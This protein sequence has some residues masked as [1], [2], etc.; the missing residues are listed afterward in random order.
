MTP[1]EKSLILINHI[2]DYI[3]RELV[4]ISTSK[5][6]GFES[7]NGFLKHL[8]DRGIIYDFCV[9]PLDTNTRSL[10]MTVKTRLDLTMYSLECFN[11]KW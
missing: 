11:P 6:V 9:L 5:D 8:M 3:E 2:N 7:V 1:Q 10:V 4:S